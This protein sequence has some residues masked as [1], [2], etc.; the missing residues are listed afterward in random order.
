[1]VIMC[2]CA[3]DRILNVREE[4]QKA[5]SELDDRKCEISQAHFT[6]H[7]SV[8]KF[9]TEIQLNLDSNK[10]RL[11][12]EFRG[13]CQKDEERERKIKKEL[14]NKKKI[15]DEQK[16]KLQKILSKSD[17]DMTAVDEVT[18]IKRI[19]ET[20]QDQI[21]QIQSEVDDIEQ[22]MS[23]AT[24]V[25]A[26]LNNAEFLVEELMG[27]LKIEDIYVNRSTSITS[28]TSITSADAD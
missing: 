2:V 20:V 16:I 6:V 7:Q 13:Y 18:S 26:E 19:I 14:E 5:L 11:K 12:K 17:F 25:Q 23:S 10:E 9:V 8:N 3:G 28:I 27:H 1:M 24:L 15:C 4:A 22:I 21:E